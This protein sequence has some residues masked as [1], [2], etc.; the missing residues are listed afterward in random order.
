MLPLHNLSIENLS[1][2]LFHINIALLVTDVNLWY[3][4]GIILIYIHS[5]EYDDIPLTQEGVFFLLLDL[6][7]VFM[8]RMHHVFQGLLATLGKFTA[9]PDGWAV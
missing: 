1:L 4:L 8:K 6:P 2:R 5:Q 9:S 7:R 3:S